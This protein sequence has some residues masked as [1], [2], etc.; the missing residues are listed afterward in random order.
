MTPSVA[1][2]AGVEVL[3]PLTG[4]NRNPSSSPWLMISAPMRRVD[5]PH[6]VCHAKS[7]PPVSVENS[8]PK[9]FEKFW[10]SSCDVDI[11][12]ALPSAITP[13][14][15]HDVVAPANRSLAVLRPT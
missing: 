1:A 14:V 10:P 6:E 8:V 11:C 7:R 3:G 4:G 15:V 13:S 2:W 9:A 5:A 12:S